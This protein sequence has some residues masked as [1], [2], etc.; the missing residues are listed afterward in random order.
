MLKIG[1]ILMP[2]ENIVGMHYLQT[3]A[4]R[5]ATFDDRFVLIGTM[6]TED[7]QNLGHLTGSR[8]TCIL[9]SS[10]GD[11]VHLRDGEVRSL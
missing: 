7:D 2:R 8:F 11:I 4:G 9:L 6:C 1:D 5:I 10:R 3:G